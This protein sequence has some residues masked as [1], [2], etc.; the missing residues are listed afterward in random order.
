MIIPDALLPRLLGALRDLGAEITENSFK[1]EFRPSFFGLLNSHVVVI[2]DKN[3][4]A[5]VICRHQPTY[6]TIQELARLVN[7]SK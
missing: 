1:N 7:E 3:G 6:Q 2:Y 4:F 5:E